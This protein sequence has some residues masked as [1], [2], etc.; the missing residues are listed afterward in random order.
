MRNLIAQKI[1]WLVDDLSKYSPEKII[2]FGSAGTDNTDEY[3]DIDVVVIKQTTESFLERIKKA[4]LMLRDEI[5]S[6]DVFVYTPQ[7]F[8]KMKEMENPFIAR[9]I[10]TGKVVYEK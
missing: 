1:D 9:V 8:K 4:V 10:E 6:V 3:S 7:E 5:G 2:L